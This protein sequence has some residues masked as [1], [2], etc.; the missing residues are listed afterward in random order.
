VG[1]AGAS[2]YAADGGTLKG[3]FVYGGK[4]PT[5]AALAITADKAYCGK[6]EFKAGLVD[7]SLSVGASGGLADVFVYLYLGR[8]DKIAVHP[9]YEA[10]KSEKVVLDNHGCMFVPHTVGLWTEQTLVIGNKDTVGHNTKV[11][12]ISGKS[13][14]PLIPPG[15]KLDEK[16]TVAERLPLVVSCNIHPWMKARMLVQDHPYFAISDADG[17][18]E[19]QHIP[20]GTYDF[21][22]YH[23]RPGYVQS[24]TIGGKKESWKS[25]KF[26][27][28]ITEG[29]VFDLGDITVAPGD[30]TGG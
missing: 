8:S 30:L 23:E 13:I 29:K 27:G 28:K 20:A 15:K 3:R 16:F 12:G 21:R 7:P 17:N 11:D 2:S 1:L 19:I 6:A 4:A 14:N 24:V 9:S 26:E 5:P 10:K 25:G 22:A 18:F